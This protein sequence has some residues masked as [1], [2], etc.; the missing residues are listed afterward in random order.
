VQAAVAVVV[1]Q[2]AQHQAAV[3]LEVQE[4]AL[5]AQLIQVVELVEVEVTHL[6]QAVQA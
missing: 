4:L 5:V 1:A 3:E 6:H 2:V